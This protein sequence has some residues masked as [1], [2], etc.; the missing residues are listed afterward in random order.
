M[1]NYSKYGTF[2]GATSDLE[3]FISKKNYKNFQKTIDKKWKMIYNKKRL[4]QN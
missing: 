4:S 3:Y 2:I 1:K